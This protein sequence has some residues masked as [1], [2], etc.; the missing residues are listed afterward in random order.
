MAKSLRSKKKQANKRVMREKAK[1]IDLQKHDEIT[2][3]L[4]EQ[5]QSFNMSRISTLRKTLYKKNS[6]DNNDSNDVDM[7]DKTEELKRKVLGVKKTI[8]KPKKIAPAG[9]SHTTPSA[10]SRGAAW[11]KLKKSSAPYR[12]RQYQRSQ[13]RLPPYDPTAPK[14][15]TETNKD[16][17]TED[18]MA[19]AE[20]EEQP[21]SDEQKQY[22]SDII[23]MENFHKNQMD[24]RAR[25]R[26]VCPPAILYFLTAAE[27]FTREEQEAKDFAVAN[28]K[29]KGSKAVPK[30]EES[31]SEQKKKDLLLTA[32][33]TDKAAAI[34][35]TEAN[36]FYKRETDGSTIIDG[37]KYYLPAGYGKY[38]LKKPEDVLA[39][40]LNDVIESIK[41]AAD[42]KIRYSLFRKQHER[43][44]GEKVA[45]TRTRIKQY[46]AKH[47]ISPKTEAKK[48]AQP[49]G[50]LMRDRINKMRSMGK[51]K[52]KNDNS[53]LRNASIEQVAIAKSK[54]V[55]REGQKVQKTIQKF[56]KGRF[57]VYGRHK[58]NLQD[59]AKHYINK[60]F[61]NA[62]ASRNIMYGNQ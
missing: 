54:A 43:E 33:P 17:S 7:Q 52:S 20:G 56:N 19:E 59:A 51:N 50:L 29:I 40:H 44:F 60:E 27:R 26:D 6:G 24:H 48:A 25:L 37:V 38:G 10:P 5:Q 46:Q 42:H 47:K 35:E 39:H 21:Q 12:P 41:R 18:K 49:L 45:A 23:F 16:D 31:F 15:D 53:S 4:Y 55:A 11:L 22:K 9:P 30:S 61:A 8:E 14:T 62:M 57:Q 36:E 2:Q 32:S 58:N 13:N 3:K 34:S 1:T 28:Y